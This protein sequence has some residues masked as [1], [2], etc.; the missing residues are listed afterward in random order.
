MCRSPGLHNDEQALVELAKQGSTAAFGE[1]YDRHVA[2][3]YHYVYTLLGN[4]SDAE[5]LTAETFLRALQAVKRY[6]WTGRPVSSWLLTIARNL[7]MNQ[8]RRRRRTR[9]AFHLFLGSNSSE[10]AEAKLARGLDIHELRQAVAALS[11]MQREVIILRFVL[12]LDY[13]RV[14]QVVGKSVNNVRVIQCRALQRLYEKLAPTECLDLL[15]ASA[16]ATSRRRAT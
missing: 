1:L 8:L 11:P 2:L 9:D 14:A 3:V 4:K 10:P 16:A 5:D 13:P 12:D 7:G 6:R 15:A